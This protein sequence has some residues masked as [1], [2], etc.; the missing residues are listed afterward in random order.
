MSRISEYETEKS[1]LI[2]SVLANQDFATR[3]WNETKLP[4]RTRGVKLS[5]ACRGRD[6]RNENLITVTTGL[7][8]TQLPIRAIDSL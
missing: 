1:S 6:G 4:E 2:V 8:V 5:R 3:R 7:F